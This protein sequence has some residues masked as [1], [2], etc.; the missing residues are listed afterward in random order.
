MLYSLVSRDTACNIAGSYNP[1]LIGLPGVT[2][3]IAYAGLV[4]GQVLWHQNSQNFWHSPSHTALEGVAH[5]TASTVVWPKLISISWSLSS[6]VQGYAVAA[7]PA[8]VPA[9]AAVGPAAARSCCLR[10]ASW[11]QK[12]GLTSGYWFQ[13]GQNIRLAL[14]C[15]LQGYIMTELLLRIASPVMVYPHFSNM[16][17]RCSNAYYI[18]TVSSLQ[19]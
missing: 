16:H 13:W 4:Q 18:I 2:S 14:M 5:Q 11:L 3:D 15:C 10:I 8:V 1:G 7:V 17:Y 19:L 9:A 12:T 6:S